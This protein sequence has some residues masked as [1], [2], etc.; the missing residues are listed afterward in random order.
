MEKSVMVVFYLF[1]IFVVIVN[2]ITELAARAPLCYCRQEGNATCKQLGVGLLVVT[3]GL[4]V[5]TSYSSSCYHL[6]SANK[7]QNVD[8]LIPAYAGLRGRLPPP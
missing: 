1:I 2:I 3:I 5:C 6:L 4:E 8:I 7:I